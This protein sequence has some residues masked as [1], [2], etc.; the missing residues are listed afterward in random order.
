M[1][2]RRVVGSC[3]TEIM[4][5][6]Y[7]F[8]PATPTDIVFLHRAVAG[9]LCG[10]IVPVAMRDPLPP[11]A[12][13]STGN[14]RRVVPQGMSCDGS[15]ATWFI[16]CTTPA[17]RVRAFLL[18]LLQYWVGGPGLRSQPSSSS[19]TPAEPSSSKTAW[20]ISPSGIFLVISVTIIATF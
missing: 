18:S 9:S 19:A 2:P 15:V 4:G 17:P 11:R 12:C 6:C 20:T 3:S 14:P 16:T 7:G 10:S 1:T 5:S 13:S 8:L